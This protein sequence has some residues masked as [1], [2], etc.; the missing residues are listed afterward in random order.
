MMNQ[1]VKWLKAY[2]RIP[3][4]FIVWIM[5]RYKK[6]RSHLKTF[7]ELDIVVKLFKI[8]LAVT[9]IVWLSIAFMANDEQKKSLS[10][11]LQNTWQATQK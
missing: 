1:S 7:M 9:I 2:F 8:G 4:S 11:A 6:N 10:N 3:F 5:E